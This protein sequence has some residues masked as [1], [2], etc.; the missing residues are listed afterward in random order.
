MA[1]RILDG[2]AEINF[3]HK[4]HAWKKCWVSSC[5]TKP[6]EFHANLGAYV[7]DES[8]LDGLFQICSACHLPAPAQ[9]DLVDGSCSSSQAAVPQRLSRSLRKP[10]HDLCGGAWHSVEIASA[11]TGN[12]LLRFYVPFEAEDDHSFLDLVRETAVA[13]FSA[14]YWCFD[15]LHNGSLLDDRSTWADLGYPGQVHLVSKPKVSDWTQDLFD[16]IEAGDV[17]QVEAVLNRGQD[18][19]CV[20]IDSALCAA[21]QNNHYPVVR[22]LLKAKADVN[23]VPL[24]RPGPLQTA[25][26]HDA[27]ECTKLLLHSAANPNLRDRTRAGNG[28]LHLAAVY[29]DA[30][31]ADVLI[32]HGAS[33]LLKNAFDACPVT[34]ARPGLVTSLCL[35]ECFQEMQQ[36]TVLCRHTVLLHLFGCSASLWVTC[37]ALNGSKPYYGDLAGGSSPGPVLTG[38]EVN[39]MD[40]TSWAR[41]CRNRAKALEKKRKAGDYLKE[42]DYDSLVARGLTPSEIDMMSA[43]RREAFRRRCWHQL[44]EQSMP[45]CLHQSFD[46]ASGKAQG[47]RLPLPVDGWVPADLGCMPLDFLGTGNLGSVPAFDFLKRRNSHERDCRLKFEEPSHTYYVDG[48]PVELSVTGFLAGFQRPFDADTVISRMEQQQ[49]WPRQ[50]YLTFKHLRKVEAFARGSPFLW[51]LLSLLQGDPIDKASVCELLQQAPKDEVWNG[52]RYLLTMTRAEIKAFWKRNGEVASRLGT[53]AHL[54]CECVLNGGQVPSPSLSPE[55]LCLSRFLQTSERLIAHR[56]EWSIWAADEKLAGTIDFCATDPTGCLVLVDWKRSKNLKIKY[57]T[58]FQ[59]MKGNFSHIPDAVGWKYRLQL[60]LYKYIVEKYYGFS[61]SRMLVV[62]IHPDAQKDPFVDEVPNMQADVKPILEARAQQLLMSDDLQGGATLSQASMDEETEED[63]AMA[64]AFEREAEQQTKN[65]PIKLE[66]KTTVQ[67]AFPD[68]HVEAM[69]TQDAAVSQE[70]KKEVDEE[71]AEEI[72]DGETISKIKRRRLLKGAFTS[73]SDFQD[74]FSGYQDI[75]KRE[76][77]NLP[78]DCDFS[79]HSTLHRS[80]LLREAVRNQ[81]PTWD[82]DMLRLGAVIL[83]VCNM[84]VSDRMFVGDSAFLLWMIEGNSTIRVHSGF[85]YIY[86]DDGAFLP[87]SGTPPEALL[88]RVSLFCTI[89]EGRLK[90]LPASTSLA[91]FRFYMNLFGLR[92]LSKLNV[93]EEWC[94]LISLTQRITVDVQRVLSSCWKGSSLRP[95]KDADI[96]RAVA[97]D[98][99]LFN[100]DKEYFLTCRDSVLHGAGS[101]QQAFEPEERLEDSEMPAGDGPAPA[102][103]EAESWIANVSKRLWR[104]CHSMRA[105]LMHE[106]LISLLVEWCETP[107]AESSCV[108]YKDTCVEFLQEATEDKILRH[109]PKSPVNNC[110]LYIPHNLLDPVMEANCTKLCQ[111]YAHTFWANKDVFLCCQAALALAKRG[112]N[113]DRC[114]I[115]ESPG[116]V[117]QSLYSLHLDTMLGNNHGFFDPNVWYNEDELRKQVETFARCIVITG[118]EAPESAKKLHLDLFKKTMSG[119]GI[120]GRKPYGFTTKMFHLIGWKRLEINRMPRFAGITA[121]N[122]NSI[123]RR[124]LLWS[125]VQLKRGNV[126]N[127]PG[128]AKL[129]NSHKLRQHSLHGWG[130]DTCIYCPKTIFW[131]TQSSQFLN[132]GRSLTKEKRKIRFLVYIYRFRVVKFF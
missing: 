43:R 21:V 54:Q 95:R 116:G 82:E 108:A 88:S 72:V 83:A 122:F 89:M 25:V 92:L 45:T 27:E 103:S 44:W 4:S 59:N 113:I 87:Y 118:Q 5:V 13:A 3:A 65:V 28:P 11:F 24:G 104:V 70:C 38:A 22:K 49:T 100:S 112:L 71:P 97:A 115:G 101:R 26:I 86:N 35:A 123:F 110:Y 60:N 114:F 68:R 52:A 106:R 33:P 130:N 125:K 9:N 132:F 93:E 32:S 64:A 111:F 80:R 84:R 107:R 99:D 66:P 51:P 109:V 85:C 129:Q 63:A 46:S 41:L 10:L 126:Q 73:A 98:R 120:A 61:V 102:S 7:V 58:S 30:V 50:E 128:Q 18:P 1:F 36:A 78:S 121:A 15:V 6:V 75:A 124:G 31:F 67:P 17:P 57:L 8:L 29:G 53:W 55:M 69:E 79:E 117:G 105:E 56:T 131:K 16:A 40:S 23:F 76:L 90:R 34:L 48:V 2:D 119:D 39:S 37:K 96:I 74:M 127:K 20:L 42:I 94:F 14:P 62:D 47:V 91:L 81:K 12:S 19:D 77:A